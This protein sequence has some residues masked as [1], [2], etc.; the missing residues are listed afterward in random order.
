MSPLGQER[1]RL[2]ELFALLSL[3][4]D[5]GLGQPMEHMIRACLIALRLGERLDLAE[6]ERGVVYYSGLLAW[7][8][9][10]TDAYKQA[11]WF[12]DD[13]TLKGDAHYRNDM[14]KPGPAIAFMLKHVG[15]PDRPLTT[16]TRVGL[17]FV[18]DGL[19]AMKSL[20]ESHYRA[21]EELVERLSLYKPS[22]RWPSRW[23]RR[24]STRTGPT[25]VSAFATHVP[26]SPRLAD[27]CIVRM[28]HR[29]N[30][31]RLTSDAA[32]LLLQ[33]IRLLVCHVSDHAGEVGRTIA[34]GSRDLDAAA[35]L[36]AIE[37]SSGSWVL[38][39]ELVSRQHVHRL[40]VVRC[41]GPHPVRGEAEA[42]AARGARSRCQRRLPRAYAPSG[43]GHPIPH[44]DGTS[45]LGRRMGLA[46]SRDFVGFGDHRGESPGRTAAL[47]I[48]LSLTPSAR[49]I[50]RSLIPSSRRCFALSAIFR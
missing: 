41:R 5:L 19:R 25:P 8:G 3:G 45:W 48:V 37:R 21:T 11:K 7:V 42:T 28:M 13:T 6:S 43:C 1:V 49:A 16:R 29:P 4:T 31:T 40:T 23:S 22:M 2:A 46:Q 36:S 10:H 9:C 12:G 38:S 30:G 26:V 15:G 33:A 24:F 17:G 34:F 32:L 50:A 44:P 14:G 18:R 39:A 27:G 35:I 47:A 20:A